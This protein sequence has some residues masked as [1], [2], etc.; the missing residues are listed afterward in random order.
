[1]SELR[2]LLKT[3][4]KL[5]AQREWAIAGAKFYETL[6]SSAQ[7]GIRDI[8]LA[9]EKIQ[10][11]KRRSADVAHAVRGA[12]KPSNAVRDMAARA[13]SD[14]PPTGEA[15]WIG[16][17]THT[18]RR[19][20]DVFKDALALWK[21]DHKFVPTPEQ[22]AKLRNRLA[23]AFHGAALNKVILSTGKGRDRVYRLPKRRLSSRTSRKHVPTGVRVEKQA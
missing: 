17:L 11:E 9:L 13:K 16:F 15:F 14:L 20:G 8:D 7:V 19:I 21:R 23:V 18:D 22:S 2:K 6:Q 5:V 1:M 4:E 10:E 3:R 12:T